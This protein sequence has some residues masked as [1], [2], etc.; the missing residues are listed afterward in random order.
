LTEVDDMQVK[1]SAVQPIAFRADEDERN[2]DAALASIDEA[3]DAGA[4]L[5]CFPEGY[6]GPG[7]VPLRYSAV[8]RLEEKARQRNVFIVAGSLEPAHGGERYYVT[9]KLIGP[10]G[11]V[12]VYHRTTPEGPY[13]YAEPPAP[14]LWGFDYVSGDS[15]PV[16][17][18][19]LGTIGLLVCSEIYVPELARALMLCGAE[20]V[21]AP[22]GAMINELM[23]TWR[24]MIWARAIENLLYTVTC[25]N[26]YG[27]EEGVA[28][29]AG[30]EG[31]LAQRPDAGIITATLDLDRIRWLR[32]Q[33]ERIEVPKPYSV[34]PGTLRWR[35]PE[36]YGL[37]TAAGSEWSA[38]DPAVVR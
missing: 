29:I 36:L 9:V 24:T 15:L 32:D 2:V 21:L 27:G 7:G 37:L 12:G 3:A 10:G 18:T 1:V 20:I 28:M 19:P 6:P 35:R 34:I 31:I 16:F 33:D 8:E 5:I 22:A 30:P 26:L 17:E 13:I 25:Q 11:V 14:G 38:P 4:Q 23:P